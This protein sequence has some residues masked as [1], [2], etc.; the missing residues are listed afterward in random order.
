[1]Y[2]N[3]LKLLS[4]KCISNSNYDLQFNNNNSHQPEER[5]NINS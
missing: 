4:F 1:M 5:G 2:Y 3:I